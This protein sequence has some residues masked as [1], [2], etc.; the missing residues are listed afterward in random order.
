MKN[1]KY[2]YIICLVFEW[3]A[4]SAGDLEACQS[5]IVQLEETNASLLATAEGQIAQQNVILQEAQ[6]IIQSLR[7]EIARN[8]EL[9]KTQTLND[10]IVALREELATANERNELLRKNLNNLEQSYQSKASTEETTEQEAD[11]DSKKVVRLQQVI[12]DQEAQLATLSNI[13]GDMASLQR[14]ILDLR[15]QLAEV[16]AERN[17]LLIDQADKPNQKS[18][19][20]QVSF[21]TDEDPATDELMSTSEDDLAESSRPGSSL[22]DELVQYEHIPQY[23]YIQE[24]TQKIRKKDLLIR[25]LK[26]LLKNKNQKFLELLELHEKTKSNES[27]FFIDLKQAERRIQDLQERLAKFTK[28]DFSD[29]GIFPG[30]DSFIFGETPPAAHQPKQPQ[31]NT[32]KI[33]LEPAEEGLTPNQQILTVIKPQTTDIQKNS[34]EPAEKLSYEEVD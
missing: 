27:K 23:S 34:L 17:K 21:D 24:L 33:S 14:T 4:V 32:K 29:F 19:G 12:H 26:L 28:S 1:F 3:Q 11:S 5:R 13:S 20:I 16:T 15:R 31:L 25:R 7:K 30:L 10:Q 2:I 6:E 8:Q 22:A 18:I 9:D